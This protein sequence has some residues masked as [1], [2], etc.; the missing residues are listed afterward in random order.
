ML[1][2]IDFPPHRLKL[3]GVPIPAVPIWVPL[4]AV[5]AIGGRKSI[6]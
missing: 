3:G 4:C 2:L 6:V 5:F 1:F